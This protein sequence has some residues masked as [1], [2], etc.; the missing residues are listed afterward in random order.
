VVAGA[1]TF[2]QTMQQVL[3]TLEHLT[4]HTISSIREGNTHSDHS[5]EDGSIV[6]LLMHVNMYELKL[7]FDSET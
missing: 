2:F 7:H 1:S 3:K 5:F 6:D 4:P